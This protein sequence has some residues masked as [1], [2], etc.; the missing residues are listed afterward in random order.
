MDFLEGRWHER[1]P[2]MERLV[3]NRHSGFMREVDICLR[4]T[5]WVVILRFKSFFARE[6]SAGPQELLCGFRA[7]TCSLS[8]LSAA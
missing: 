1:N 7:T 2:R 3:L 4:L 6:A 8:A 5:R